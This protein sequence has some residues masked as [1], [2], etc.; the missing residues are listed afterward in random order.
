MASR[1]DCV[2]CGNDYNEACFPAAAYHPPYER[3]Q[4][5]SYTYRSLGNSLAACGLI[6]LPAKTQGVVNRGTDTSGNSER[7]RAQESSLNDGIVLGRV[8]MDPAL[9]NDT[10]E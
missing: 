8:E 1:L 9:I 2:H 10:L 3:Q 4:Q 5:R 6:S 7:Q